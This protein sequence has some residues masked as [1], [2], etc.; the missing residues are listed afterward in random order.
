MQLSEGNASGCIGECAG[1]SRVVAAGMS[2][3]ESASSRDRVRPLRGRNSGGGVPGV[4]ADRFAHRRTP[5][6]SSVTASRS[7]RS[8][9]VIPIQSCRT[10]PE[11]PRRSR[12]VVPIQCGPVDQMRS[13]SSSALVPIQH[14]HIDPTRPCRSAM[15]GS[16]TD[17]WI[18]QSPHL[19]QGSRGMNRAAC[20]TTVLLERTG[21]FGNDRRAFPQYTRRSP[22]R[23]SS[24]RRSRS[25]SCWVS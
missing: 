16:T 22:C 9:A 10:H 13:F 7:Y 1:A 25:M 4:T 5:R 14:C 6:L 18:E 3:A 19:P 24:F 20:L 23:I 12:S 15:V 21:C 8:R 17:R 2:P 11:R